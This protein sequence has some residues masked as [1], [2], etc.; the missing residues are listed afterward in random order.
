MQDM[1]LEIKY[2]SGNKNSSSDTLSRYSVD[3]PAIQ[4]GFAELGGVVA[5]LDLNNEL[6]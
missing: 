4:D 2:I 1:N 3:A 6:N 5:T